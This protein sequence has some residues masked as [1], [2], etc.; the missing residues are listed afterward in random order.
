MSDSL[1]IHSSAAPEASRQQRSRKAIAVWLLVLCA[2]VF[3]MVVLGGVTRL[4][5]SGLSM[6]EWRPVTGWLPPLT[7]AEWQDAFTKYQQSPE[8]QKV[9]KGMS[10]DE[11]KTIFWFEFLH[12]LWGRAIGVA[13]AI[14][15][16]FFLFTRRLD[17]SLAPKLGLMFVLGGLQGV[18]GW[19]MVKSG[20]VDRPDVS[21]YRLT[22]HLGAALVILAYMFWVALGLLAPDREGPGGGLSRAA[23][24]LAALVFATALSG[25]FVAGLDAGFAYNTFPL[26]DGGLWPDDFFSLSP[27]WLNLFEHIPT[28]QWDHRLMATT[29][30]VLVLLFRW[31]AHGAPMGERAYRAMNLLVLALLVQVALGITTLLL[32]VPITIA[33]LHQAGALVLFL[34]ALWTAFEFRR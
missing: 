7:D 24:G 26:M 19:Y 13:F 1:A 27:W 6:V 11:F 22:A 5:E 28:V 25:G 30:F 12:R 9:N 14:P 3:A 20:L 23:A 32:V 17:W 18:L 29:V 34:A 16:L 31:R 4:T 10:V 15:F 21:Q 8:Y 2:M 33:A